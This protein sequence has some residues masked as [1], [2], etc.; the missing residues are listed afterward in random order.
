MALNRF[1]GCG[2]LVRDIELKRTTNGIPVASF[3]VAIERDYKDANGEKVADFVDCVAWRTSAEYVAKYAQKGDII[4]LDGRL[5]YRKFTD[6]NGVDR[7][8]AEIQINSVYCVSYHKK[9]D[10]SQQ[11]Q[12]SEVADDGDLPF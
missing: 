5:E 11:Q 8:I 6:K 10:A 7:R 12:F 4:N 1:C 2:R 3:T 9:D